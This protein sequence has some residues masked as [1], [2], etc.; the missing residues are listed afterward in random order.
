MKTQAKKILLTVLGVLSL[1]IAFA[2]DSIRCGNQIVT[3]GDSRAVVRHKCGVPEDISHSVIRESAANHMYGR[4]R[5]ADK[6]EFEILIQVESW[7][8]NFGPNRF[9]SRIRFVDGRLDFIETLGYG[10]DRNSSDRE[11]P[12]DSIER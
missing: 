6:V 9:M 11:I 8:Y 12:Y 2:S 3:F 4:V 7:L 5:Y 10:Y 1:N